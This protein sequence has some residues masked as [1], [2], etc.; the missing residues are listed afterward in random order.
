MSTFGKSLAN[1]TTSTSEP[2]FF[3]DDHDDTSSTTAVLIPT[4]KKET[5]LQPLTPAP[6]KPGEAVL[7]HTNLSDKSK[8]IWI[9]TTASL[10]WMT[11]TA[12][13]ALLRAA[14]LTRDRKAAGG[15]VTILLPWLE[16]AVDQTNVY[17]AYNSFETPE[18]Q[19]AYVRGWL[20]NS[21][22]LADASDE[23]G[24]Q[25]YT[26]WQN[27]VENSIYSMG[28][29][30]ALIPEEDV[31]ICILEEP[32]HLNWCVCIGARFVCLCVCIFSFPC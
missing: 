28:D 13:N 27:K 25:W 1:T 7:P 9:V 18:Q 16:R 12:V 6:A 3:L 4:K 30:T 2:M 26:A 23:L 21:A 14:Y 5:A 20:R 8:R 19:E 24:I 11:G 22:G 10:P 29:I 32:E 31:D 17:G 15:K